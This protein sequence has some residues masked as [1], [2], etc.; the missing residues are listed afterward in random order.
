VRYEDLVR[1]PRAEMAKLLEF[2]GLAMDT[3]FEEYLSKPLPLSRYTKTPPR[4]DKWQQD[5]AEIER[6][7][8]AIASFSAR[9]A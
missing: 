6:V 7:M 3:R 5:A 4:P 2:A 1:D 8:P 9:L